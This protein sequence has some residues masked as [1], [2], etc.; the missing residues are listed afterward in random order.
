MRRR[1]KA[2]VR[3]SGVA[4]ARRAHGQRSISR[5]WVRG[6]DPV[7][8]SV[9]WS[10]RGDRG[11]GGRWPVKS[12]SGH[13]TPSSGRPRPIT[14]PRRLETTRRAPMTFAV[15][16]LVRARGREWIVQPESQHHED[17]LVDADDETTGV[18][19]PLERSSPTPSPSP[20]P[21]PSSAT[22]VPASCCATPYALASAPPPDPSAPW[23]ASPSSPGPTSS[24]RS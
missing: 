21:M 17:L 7:G 12:V 5:P 22:T 9:Y 15:G 3:R 4:I 16:S 11:L 23:A 18:Y 13:L 1:Y 14:S 24:C 6:E 10:D 19:L 8:C 20:T 2:G